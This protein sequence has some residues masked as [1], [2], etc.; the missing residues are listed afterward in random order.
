MAFIQLIIRRYPGDI[1]VDRSTWDGRVA[2]I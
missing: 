2:I 1:E